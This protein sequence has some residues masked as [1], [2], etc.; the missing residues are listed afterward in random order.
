MPE[1]I[2]ALFGRA[3]N[4]ADS[5]GED[6]AQTDSTQSDDASVAVIDAPVD[7]D[8]IEAESTEDAEDASDTDLDEVAEDESTG[9]DLADSDA[10][11]SD[12][13]D[14]DDVAESDVAD[15]DATDE[16][17]ADEDATDEV[18]E[19]AAADDDDDLTED[20]VADEDGESVSDV[21]AE[22]DDLDVTEP[23]VLPVAVET[24]AAA[25]TRGSITVGDGVV[26][27]VVSIVAGK[28][29]G[30]HGLDDEGVSVAVD[31]EIATVTLSLVVEYGHAVKAVAEQIRIDVIEA[32]E[33]FLGLDVAAVDVHVSDIHS[34]AAV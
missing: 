7:T 25:G 15:E 28:V 9:D 4:D 26:V 31:G 22:V 29:D 18:A 5:S 21:E 32:V 34:P 1:I 27:K 11:D 16:D 17:A 19:V 10:E 12:D 6:V 8:A 24:R 14:S 33:Q 3:K 13:V 20:A 2:N 30:V 23:V